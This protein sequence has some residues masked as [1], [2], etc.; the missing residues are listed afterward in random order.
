MI[1]YLLNDR[2]RL[3]QGYIWLALLYS[4]FARYQST[5][6]PSVLVPPTHPPSPSLLSRAEVQRAFPSKTFSLGISEP[7]VRACRPVGR[8]SSY[9]I[10]HH[11]I[12]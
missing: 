1:A 7:H 10:E 6:L 9:K 2:R 3:Q 12:F 4:H 8:I 5:Y 11:A